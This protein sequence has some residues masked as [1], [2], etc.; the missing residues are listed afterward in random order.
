M[1]RW[2]GGNSQGVWAKRGLDLRGPDACCWQHRCSSAT[3]VTCVSLV[4]RCLFLFLCVSQEHAFESS[5][6][7]KEGKYIIELAHM[8]KDNGWD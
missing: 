5:Q 6:K 7:Y 3:E 1:A 8:I 4:I 2:S